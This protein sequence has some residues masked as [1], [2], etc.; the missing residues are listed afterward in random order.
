MTALAGRPTPDELANPRT[1]I[2]PALFDRLTAR[3]AA[4]ENI[5]LSDAERV[6]EQALAFLV[7]CALNPG[8]SLSPSEQVDV[9]WHTFLTYTRDY[10]EFCRRVAHRYIHHV[11]AGTPGAAIGDPAAAVGATVEAMR[12]AGLPVIADLWIP[13]SE[14]SQCHQGCYDDPKEG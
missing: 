3:I 1:L 2:H 11:P 5:P 7:A 4:D 13:R 9:G 8:A 6:M 14:C 10:T 12:A